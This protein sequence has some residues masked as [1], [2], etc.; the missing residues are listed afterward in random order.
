MARP[1]LLP[2]LLRQR[3]RVRPDAV[4]LAVDGGGSL[5]LRQWHERSTNAGRGLTTSGVAAGDRVALVFDN[6]R[7]LDLAVAYLAVL[8]AGA[9][10]V[11]LTRRFPAWD[12][13]RALSDCDP[14]LVIGPDDLAVGRG[15][16]ARA[17]LADLEA[18][19][20]PVPEDGPPDP[21]APAEWLYPGEA[22]RHP[23]PERFTHADIA[24][25]T[26]AFSG[27]GDGTFVH[28]FPIG[29]LAGQEAL[30]LPLRQED[31]VAVAVAAFAP[32][33]FVARAARRGAI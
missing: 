12:L 4:A 30:R 19:T 23:V 32:D 10:A 29:T 20:A 6:R 9:V 3:A 5:T 14:A 25:P 27:I 2:D 1:A 8:R 26:D 15:P 18:E 13:R 11:P 24:V 17:A 22:M 31:S 28:A 33:D 16:W 21:D 7:W